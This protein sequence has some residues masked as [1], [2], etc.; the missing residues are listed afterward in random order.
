MTLWGTLVV[1]L[2]PQISYT[3][4]WKCYNLK[5][6][7]R[8]QN[9]AKQSKAKWSRYLLFWPT[10]LGKGNLAGWVVLEN[11]HYILPILLRKL[12]TQAS[13]DWGLYGNLDTHLTK[14]VK[15]FLNLYQSID[16]EAKL[17]PGL[18]SLEAKL[19][20]RLLCLP[21][22]RILKKILVTFPPLSNI[23][24]MLFSFLL[25]KIHGSSN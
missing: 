2:L 5:M 21:G 3:Q 6:S 1:F 15:K 7:T 16:G 12:F 22:V 24:D 13:K 9:K 11:S 17:G 23:N 18:S 4:S 20:S 25:R 8:L 14:V 19:G 10:E